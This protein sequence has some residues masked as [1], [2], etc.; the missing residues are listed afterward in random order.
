MF[1]ALFLAVPLAAACSKPSA[2]ESESEAKPTKKKAGKVDLSDDTTKADDK[3]AASNAAA[4][5][6]GAPGTGGKAAD[7]KANAAASRAVVQEFAFGSVAWTFEAEGVVKA[8]VRDKSGEPIK[9]GFVGSL[10]GADGKPVELAPV[11]GAPTAS[12]ALYGAELPAFKGDLTPVSYVVQVGADPVRGTLY[13]PAGGTTVMLAPPATPSATVAV[14][15][16]VKGPHGGIVQLVGPDRV[17]IVSDQDSGEVR[18]YV[19]DAS[20]TPIVVGERRITLGV[21]ADHSELVSL[22]PVE[23]GA[24]FVA[25]WGLKADPVSI[26]VSVRVG[27]V[28]SFGLV[29]WR[30]GIPYV[31]VRPEPWRVRL[32]PG[33]GP[34]TRVLVRGRVIE[35]HEPRLTRRGKVEVGVGLGLGGKGGGEKVEIKGKGGGGEK[36]EIKPKGGGGGGERV[37][38]K[39][40][41]GGGGGERV[42]IKSKGGGGGGGG[43]GGKGK[44]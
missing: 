27:A 30:P 12:V 23:G 6:A 35:A 20:L 11:E 37:E 38:I 44:K 32:K 36:I 33:W 34:P 8:D 3:P 13:V 28:V 29:G 2:D 39:S 19:L 24:Y 42:E 41:G 31:V 7:A 26:S 4:E 15:V 40:K 22:E 1:V 18:A 9:E 25:G 14:G 10:E 16:D 5:A 17:E 43:G 21:V